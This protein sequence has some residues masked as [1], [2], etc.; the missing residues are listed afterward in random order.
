MTD[1]KAIIADDEAQLRTYL[2]SKLYELWPELQICGEAENGIEALALIGQCRAFV[3]ND[4]GLMHVGA[5]LKVPLVAIFGSTDHIATGPFCEQQV[6][7]RK[8]LDCSPCMQQTCPK[9][10]LQCLELIQPDEIMAGIE[11]LLAWE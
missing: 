3:T 2:K 5:A 7:I 9:K 4:S 8:E 11:R 10:H 6:I 1:L